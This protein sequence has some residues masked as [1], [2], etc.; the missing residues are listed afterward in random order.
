[1]GLI[2]DLI[3]ADDITEITVSMLVNALY[4]KVA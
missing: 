3:G 4:L 1:M 2:A